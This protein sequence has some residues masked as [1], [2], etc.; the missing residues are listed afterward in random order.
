MKEITWSPEAILDMREIAD[1]VSYQSEFYANQVID[2]I[3]A[4]T[5]IL[6]EQRSAEE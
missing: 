5:A 4:R 2:A 1:Y 6:P 3:I